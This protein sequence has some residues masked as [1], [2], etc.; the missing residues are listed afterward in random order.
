MFASDIVYLC[1]ALVFCMFFYFIFYRVEHM[2]NV[3]DGLYFRYSINTPLV[4]SANTFEMID[5]DIDHI[6][7]NHDIN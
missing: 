2:I 5:I 6:V 7:P 3:L 1:H 4:S